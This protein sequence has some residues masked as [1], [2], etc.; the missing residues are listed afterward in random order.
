MALSQVS[1]SQ[2]HFS[3]A[4]LADPEVYVGAGLNPMS[5]YGA[6]IQKK[7]TRGKSLITKLSQSATQG[8][9][10]GNWKA[11]RR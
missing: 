2:A 4:P 9:E 1:A 10:A 5:L 11:R 7:E 6:N 8:K 3:E